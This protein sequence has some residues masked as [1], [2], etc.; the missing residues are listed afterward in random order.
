MIS[1]NRSKDA[2]KKPDELVFIH[3]SY[4]SSLSGVDLRSTLSLNPNSLHHPRY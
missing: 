4:I 1:R 2:V 3:Q